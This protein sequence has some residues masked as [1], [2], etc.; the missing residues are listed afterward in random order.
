MRLQ[1]ENSASPKNILINTAKVSTNS[2]VELKPPLK[3]AGGKRW[4]VP[5]LRSIWEQN[6]HRRL[7]EPLCGGLAVTLG[8]NPELALLNDVNPH[9]INFYSW[10]K[11]GLEI[12]LPQKNDRTVFFTYRELFNQ[13][14]K[15]E[16][17]NTCEAAELFYYLNRTGYNGLCRFNRNGE[18]NV[19]FGKYKSINYSTDF[20]QYRDTFARWEFSYGDFE[21]MPLNSMDFVYADP[22][23]MSSLPIIPVGALRGKTR[24]G[25]Q[26]GWP[27]TLVQ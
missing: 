4:L 26:S 7:V 23:M 21:I 5:H 22:R 24:S 2:T 14:I 11:A 25:W 13:L 16:K 1:Q 8:L 15:E 18:F 12:S 19:P 10:I 17:A 20:L 3:W 9:L 6:R 27:G